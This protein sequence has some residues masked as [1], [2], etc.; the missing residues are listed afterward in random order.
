MAIPNATGIMEEKKYS[1]EYYKEKYNDISVLCDSAEELLATV[2]HGSLKNNDVHL[3]L[4]EPL[5]NEVIDSSDILGEE[6]ILVAESKKNHGAK[7]SKKRIEAAL[8]RI[9]MALNE[10]QRSAKLAIKTTPAAVMTLTNQIVQK[11]QN[12]IDKVLVIFLELANISLQSIMS[13]T[14]LD[15]LKARDARIALMM[16]QFT[17]SQ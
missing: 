17:V 7:Y 11:I 8:R 4:I 13:K 2:E 1:L 6:F 5:V 3:E 15:A 14:E 16:H 9:F 12:Q 10:Y